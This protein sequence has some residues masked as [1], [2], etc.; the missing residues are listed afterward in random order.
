MANAK[1]LLFLY[2]SRDGQA[3]RIGERLA[4][5]A[6]T[7]GW[8]IHLMDL[9]QGIPSAE[10]LG[11]AAV[12]VVVAAIRYG[13]H[14]PEAER[15]MT[16]HRDQLR[17][18]PL[19]VVSVNLTARKPGKDTAEGNAYLRRWLKRHRLRPDLAQAIAGKLDYPRYTWL[20]RQLIRL[21]M[22][23]TGGPT[24]PSTSHEFTDWPAVE[25]FGARVVDLARA[26]SRE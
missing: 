13:Y 8:P 12:V 17:A 4:A 23:I 26:V 1:E 3:R 20:D 5:C 9:G 25:A 7:A 11:S 21:I 24:D 6:R 10:L 15:L 19:V 2:A 22:S 18:R 14:L 16:L